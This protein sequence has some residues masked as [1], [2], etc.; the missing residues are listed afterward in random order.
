MN[1]NW[2]D[3]S[4]N[5]GFY[6]LYAVHDGTVNGNRVAHVTSTVQGGSAVGLLIRGSQNIAVT[7]DNLAGGD[8]PASIG[9]SIGSYMG[10]LLEPN[11]GVTLSGNTISGFVTAVQNEP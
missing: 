6:L 4:A 2:V 8:G 9:I 11:V 10:E 1:T 5:A 7:D 3:Q